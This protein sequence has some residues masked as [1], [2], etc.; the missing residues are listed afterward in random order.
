MN[1]KEVYPKLN[2]EIQSVFDL[3]GIK[4]FHVATQSDP[5]AALT[6]PVTELVTFTLQEGKSKATLQALVEQLV[7]GANAAPKEAGVFGAVWG[8]T[9]EKENV[10]AGFL[11]WASVDV[12][13][14]PC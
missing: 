5:T 3:S 4:M 10:L 6:A 8:P 1:D 11:G 13:V 12:C 7:T 14:S 2:K 9:V